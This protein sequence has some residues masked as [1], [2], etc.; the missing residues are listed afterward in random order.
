MKTKTLIHY[1]L[2]SIIEILL[3]SIS[4]VIFAFTHWNIIHGEEI[5]FTFVF[6]SLLIFLPLLSLSLSNFKNPTKIIL[7]NIITILSLA[8]FITIVEII[9]YKWNQLYISA[10]REGNANIYLIVLILAFSLFTFLTLMWMNIYLT[11][12]LMVPS[13]TN[14]AEEWEILNYY[15]LLIT[16]S[17]IYH[18]ENYSYL[19]NDIDKLLI[20]KFITDDNIERKLNFEYKKEVKKTNDEGEE[21]ITKEIVKASK[22]IILLQDSIKKTNKLFDEEFIGVISYISNVLPEIIGRSKNDIK[23]IK[24]KSLFDTYKKIKKTND[25]IDFKQKKG[26][27]S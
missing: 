17:N 2:L 24:N 11:I 26:E 8:F 10:T 1:I 4:V 12:F 19:T 13:A 14:R 9:F 27:L 7:P 22:E 15:K 23:I 5:T 18:Y 3:L 16:R 25:K 21:I 6:V 20:I